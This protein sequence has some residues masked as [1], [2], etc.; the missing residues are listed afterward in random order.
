MTLKLENV[1]PQFELKL[2]SSGKTITARPFTVKEEKVLLIAA[3]SKDENQIIQA[4]KQVVSNCIIKPEIDMEK[5]PYF[6]MDYLFIAL[7]SKS[8]GETIPV[9]FI[10]PV[11]NEQGEPCNSNMP[12]EINIENVQIDKSDI[13][14]EIKI[15]GGIVFYLKYPSYTTMKKL[16]ERSNMEKKISLIASCVDRIA[17]KNT[18]YTSKDFTPREMIAFIEGLSKEQFNPL[19]EFIDNLPGFY[20][21]VKT[22][23]PKCNT[24]HQIKYTDFQSFFL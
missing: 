1:L 2:P 6:D 15:K 8:V 11:L 9:T 14:R 20:I 22:K 13:S 16:G 24:D 17:D 21:D 4:T 3:E 10:C 7:R 18:V 23:C 19:E 12:A 5:L